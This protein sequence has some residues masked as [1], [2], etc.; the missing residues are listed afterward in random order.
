METIAARFFLALLLAGTSHGAVLW[1]TTF[2]DSSAGANTGRN[3]VNTPSSPFTD[4][5]TSTYNLTR[6]GSASPIFLTGTG[7]SVF[8]FNPQQNVDNASGAFW[9]AS[10]TFTGGTS[11]FDLS[12][13]AFQIYR[14]NNSGNTQASDAVSRTVNF[15]AYYT[16]D[17]GTTWSQFGATKNVNTTGSN[18]TNTH[19]NLDFSLASPVSV[20]LSENDFQIRFRA[21]NDSTNAGANIGITSFTVNSIP[22]PS[23][24]LLL[25]A[26]SVL[27]FTRRRA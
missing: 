26:G 25:A 24:S 16:T 6:S 17:G 13:V 9:Q 15:S 7:N 21:E 19:L 2:T 3:V 10:F 18:T 20:N 27:I 4:T 23:A 11:T 5:L 1:T 14:F 8:N 12:S 22:E